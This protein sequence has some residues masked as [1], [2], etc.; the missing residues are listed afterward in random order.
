VK[1]G[2]FVG[3]NDWRREHIWSQ[4]SLWST[5]ELLERATGEKLKAEY[6][7]RHLQRRYL[8]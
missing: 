3:L 1:N 8:A 5:P 2:R 6:F 7:V 4:A